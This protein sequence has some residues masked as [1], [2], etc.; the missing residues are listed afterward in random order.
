MKS[1]PVKRCPCQGGTLMRFVQPII[2]SILERGPDHGYSILQ[3]ISQTRLWNGEC[4]DTA[5]VYRALREM[6]GRGLVSSHVESESKAGL[7]KRVFQLTAEGEQCRQ[8]WLKTLQ[9]YRL[10]LDEVI[11]MLEMGDK[12]LPVRPE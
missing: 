1:V 5:G 7:G 8:N 11:A 12:T 3:R 9:N 10:G 2:L 6:E 4:P